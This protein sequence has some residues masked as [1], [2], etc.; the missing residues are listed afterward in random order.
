MDTISP[1]QEKYELMMQEVDGLLAAESFRRSG[2]NFR[3]R[4]SE[5]KV[6]WSVC[7]QKNRYS[8][9]DN[10]GF[11]I[12]ISA[13]WKRR[14]AWYQEH[15]PQTA[16]YGGAGDR[17]GFLMP[18]KNDKWWEMDAETSVASLAAEIRA[19]LQ[20]YVLPFFRR[21][22][23]EQTLESHTR[24]LMVSPDWKRNYPIAIESLAYGLV[25]RVD[26]AEI[27]K[28]VANVRRTGR[29]NLVSKDVIE[30]TIQR[31]LKTYG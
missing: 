24:Q 19:A 4:L 5:G 25:D 22:E 10:I 3:K 2:Q 23:S 1:T 11:T 28:R 26:A 21:F 31:V 18:E 9:R 15:M 14:P 12:N 20:S 17:I 6:R 16:W 13:E 27:E 30:A 29:M 7:F 8:T